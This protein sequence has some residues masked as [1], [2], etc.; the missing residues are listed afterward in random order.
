MLIFEEEDKILYKLIYKKNSM[1]K[2]RLELFLFSFIT[3]CGMIGCDYD[4]TP[5]KPAAAY[6]P[7]LNKESVFTRFSPDSGGMATQLVL[8]G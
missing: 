1:K 8:H 6:P 2:Y 3:A 7:D 4:L 5:I